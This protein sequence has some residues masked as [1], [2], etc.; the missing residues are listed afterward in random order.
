MKISFIED[1]DNL[2]DRLAD[3]I[4]TA[5]S[6]PQIS[7]SVTKILNAVIKGGNKAVLEK[8]LEYDR[9][10]LTT[11]EMLIKKE[12]MNE[13][14]SSL[15]PKECKALNDAIANV[16]LFHKHSYLKIGRAKICM[17]AW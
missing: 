16:S 6:D 17:V 4:P 12:E 3:F 14:S 13:S 9:A 10:S 1:E 15:D 7:S 2:F 8:T 5:G 11:H